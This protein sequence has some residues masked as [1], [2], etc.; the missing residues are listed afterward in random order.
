MNTYICRDSRRKK[1]N[2]AIAGLTAEQQELRNLLL[3]EQTA[4]QV[5]DWTV[6]DHTFEAVATDWIWNNFKVVKVLVDQD[7]LLVALGTSS[8][9]TLEQAAAISAISLP[10]PSLPPFDYL[11]QVLKAVDQDQVVFEELM[12]AA[13]QSWLKE[14][15]EKAV[16]PLDDVGVL[17]P[18]RLETLFDAP[19]SKYNED[20]NSWKL[21]IRVMPDEASVCRDNEF[22]S[23]DEVKVLEAFWQSIKQSGKV[24]AS[25]LDGDVADIAWK[26]L[27]SR[28]RPERAAWLVAN[29]DIEITNEVVTL[30]L[31]ENMPEQPTPNRVGGMPP[32]LQIFAVTTAAINGTDHHLIGRLP[33]DEHAHIDNSALLLELPSET[34]KD[35]WWSSW[36]KAKAVGMGD[37]FM[38]P[39]GITPQNIEALYVIGIGD[40]EPQAHFTAQV[41]AG[42]LSIPR[43]G[44]PT[45]SIMGDHTDEV[46]DWKVVTRVRLEAKLKPAF[47][48]Y[49]KGNLNPFEGIF[50]KTVQK[51]H[52]GSI[53][54]LHLTGK[55]D[56]LP[57]F[58]G[59]DAPDDTLQSQQLVK[60]LWPALWGHWLHEVWNIGDGAYLRG[61]WAFE[62]L[63]PEGPLMPLR[64]GDQPYGLLP[65]TSLELWEAPV[66]VDQETASQY[67]EEKV[68]VEALRTL[69]RQWPESA[70]GKRSVVG[71][72][73]AEFMQLLAQEANSNRFVQRTFLPVSTQTAIY[74][75]DNAKKEEFKY[76]AMRAYDSAISIMG[77]KPEDPY[78]ANSYAQPV[79]LPLVQFT[80]SLFRQS[81]K[82]ALSHQ[83]RSPLELA[84]FFSVF[85][86]YYKETKNYDLESFFKSSH[87]VSDG[88]EYQFGSLPNSLLIRL[89][90]NSVQTAIQSLDRD[91]KN[92]LL[93]Q[94]LKMHQK[95]TLSLSK[96]IDQEVL[97]KKEQDP[98]TGNL[99]FSTTIPV[100]KLKSL[101]RAFCATLDS[102]ANRIDPWVT[103]FAWQRLKVHSNSAQHHHRLGVYGWLDGP[104]NGQPGPT[105]SGLL[106]TPSYNQT[107]AALIMRDKYLSSSRTAMTNEV[108]FSPWQMNITSQKVRLAEEIAGEVRLG[109]HIYEI[110][111]RQVEH[112][113]GQPNKVKGLRTSLKYAMRDERK[114]PNEVC[115]GNKALAGLLAGDVDFP[116]NSGQKKALQL[117]KDSLDT[118]SDL[119]M[120]DGVIQLINRQTDRAAETMDAAA[121]FSRP[122]A[123]EFIR[124]PPSGYQLETVVLSALPFVS[125]D[126]LAGD[127]HPIRLADP[128][129]AAFLENKLGNNWTWTVINE[130]NDAL[131]GS[132]TLPMINL[133]PLD[134]ISISDELIRELVRYKLNLPLVY[135]SK[136]GNRQWEAFDIGDNFLGRCTLAALKLN[137]DNLPE[138]DVLHVLICK[139]LAI[140]EDTVIKETLPDDLQLWVAKNEKGSVLG[141]ADKTNLGLIPANEEQLNKMIRQFLNLPKVRVEAAREHQLAQHLVASLG[142]RPAAGRDLTDDKAAPVMVD[143]SIY[144]ELAARYSALFNACQQLL[145]KLNSSTNDSERSAA[146]REALPWGMV[147]ATEPADREA[148]MAVLLG[149]QVPDQA[150]PLSTLIENV[151]AAINKRLQNTANPSELATEAAISAPLAY[152]K[153]LKQQDKPDGVPS[154]AR[155]IANLAAPNARLVI[156][157]CW[158]KASLI[159]NTKLV[160]DQPEDI[161]EEW[162][163]I[164]ASVRASLARLEAL[165][166]EAAEPLISWTNSPND[167]WRTGDDNIVQ[168]NLKTRE[169]E[170]VVKMRMNRFVAAY[171]TAATWK[172]DEIAVGLIDSFN[173]AIPMPQRKTMTAFGFNAPAARAPQ[174]ILLAVPP[175]PGQ[176]LNEALLLKIVEETRMLAHARTAHVEDLGNLQALSPSM[177]LPASGPARVRLE[178]WPL[179][180]D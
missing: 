98:V 115:D 10:A 88:G 127:N 59:S 43:L 85:M 137:P 47:S 17:L 105:E 92:V 67:K 134:T 18:L 24:T 162:L 63:C 147:P 114:D 5:N 148:L 153:E 176:R 90:V 119:L 126:S 159:N 167:P 36:E 106:H 142:N 21:S 57:F 156:L 109:L 121:G 107:L 133:S 7:P 66:A 19:D 80:L 29:I 52:A 171:G 149:L 161:E 143:T 164:S 101:E 120:G 45:N 122:P 68:M 103:G 131:L 111:G 8:L 180:A 166:L 22:V 129:V 13:H 12:H 30:M 140:P 78:L 77:S 65:V 170:S 117:L 96:K 145:T 177:W 87:K 150:T 51:N 62:N 28:I 38:M 169:T 139:K 33:K 144:G 146:L 74:G 112:I 172:G 130:D 125:I 42:E 97:V 100:D 76:R 73:S 163:T 118:Y 55:A 14:G 108:G 89:L 39:A 27:N 152:H 48:L 9:I 141:L 175:I 58:P 3:S 70:R 110:I 50:Q 11:G 40:E 123:F 60:A 31:P 165:Q 25:W 86:A 41:N 72:S 174:A 79:R 26:Q 35:S 160:T 46:I 44:T 151:A 69:C 124:T 157:A 4:L 94:V 99:R 2:E 61:L 20:L 81:N 34:S 83:P 113:V 64:I 54:Q 173:E 179:F 37:D 154:L 136:A 49:E 84:E 158:S 155:A 56:A 15:I 32:A 91:P 93:L 132:V 104:F 6:T 53:I 116:M 168:Q 23:K 178:H 95:Q 138:Q 102:A 128:S 1:L 71:K 16:Y 75:L 135:I 82:V